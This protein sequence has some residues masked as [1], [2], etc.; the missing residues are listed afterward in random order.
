MLA[1]LKL[2]GL[3]A[4]H[5]SEKGAEIKFKRTFEIEALNTKRT[6]PRFQIDSTTVS[7]YT[8]LASLSHSKKGQKLL[9]RIAQR[10][11]IY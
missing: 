6:R 7:T 8:M 4:K 5:R 11:S 10:I 9:D 1:A 2:R 3:R